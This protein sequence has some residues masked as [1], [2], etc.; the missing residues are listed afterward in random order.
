LALNAQSISASSPV[1][2]ETP[3][4]GF[5]AVGALNNTMTLGMGLLVVALAERL[6]SLDPPRARAL[7]WTGFALLLTQAYN[8][9]SLN[10]GPYVAGDFSGARTLYLANTAMLLACL[11]WPLRVGRT[12]AGPVGLRL[13]A[14]FGAIVLLGV[15]MGVVAHGKAADSF[16]ATLASGL[17]GF[18]RIGG[19]GILAWVLLRTDLFGERDSGSPTRRRAVLVSIG[20]VSGLLLCQL[21]QLFVKENWI[22]GLGA[23]VAAVT[24]IPG[25]PVERG[26]RR[27]REQDGKGEE[28]YRE[29][30][31]L[32]LRDG[33]I[34]LDE[35]RHLV[36]MAGKLGVKP[37]RAYA[38]RDE[39]EAALPAR[40]AQ[41]ASR[42]KVAGQR[43]R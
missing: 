2:V 13:V 16:Q 9:G 4:W 42:P 41:R 37:E 36:I 6:P 14:G 8:Y 18:L 3:A 34:E 38:I 12:R 32:A 7:A 1:P 28:V 23:V 11:A 31:R 15:V 5:V 10:L 40:M 17:V 30:V 27:A 39:E 25:G 33:R 29:A 21:L 20:L 35:E 19:I 22:I 24:A 26:I 43:V